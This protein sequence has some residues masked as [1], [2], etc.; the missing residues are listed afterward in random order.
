[1]DGVLNILKPPGMTSGDAVGRIR[2]I[3]NVKKVG[4]TGTLDPGAA[5]VLPICIGKATKISD[6]LMKG[7]K[8]YIAELVFGTKTD[9]LDSYGNIVRTGTRE[10]AESVFRSILPKFTGRIEQIPPM[11]SAVK[12]HG[13]KLYQLARQGKTVHKPPRSVTVHSIEI[14]KMYAGGHAYLLKIRCSKG[15]YIRT[16]IDDIGAAAGAWA[17]MSFLLRTKTGDFRLEDTYTLPEIE[18]A[19]AENR[20]RHLLIPIPQALRFMKKTCCPDYL[21]PILTTG[22]PIILEKTSM[23]LQANT[24]YLVFCSQELIGIGRTDETELKIVSTLRHTEGKNHAGTA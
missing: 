5:G 1:M 15:T 22:T 8:E 12:H 2:R 6:Y 20:T 9:T 10:V 13:K 24:D 3:L 19:A 14:M 18:Q 21:Y 16:L 17:Y 7:D 23:K 4:H 11:F